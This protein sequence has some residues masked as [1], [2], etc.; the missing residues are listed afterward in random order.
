MH[1]NNFDWETLNVFIF[2]FSKCL[3]I[4]KLTNKIKQS[5]KKEYIEQYLC[6]GSYDVKFTFHIYDDQKK[7]NDHIYI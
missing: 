4:I 6:W 2:H 7:S 1:K 5:K 3:L